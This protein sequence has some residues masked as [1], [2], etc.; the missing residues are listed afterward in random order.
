MI[1]I[2]KK[3]EKKTKLCMNSLS[4]KCKSGKTTTAAAVK[5]RTRTNLLTETQT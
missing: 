3:G 2:Y 4:G 5:S 1:I